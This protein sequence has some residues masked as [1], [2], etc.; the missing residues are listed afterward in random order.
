MLKR[1]FLIFFFAFTAFAASA[2]GFRDAAQ[3]STA[4]SLYK[5]ILLIPYNPIMHL[6]DADQDISEYSQKNVDIVRG[7]FRNGLLANLSAALNYRC[8][9]RAMGT[10]TS[11]ESQKELDMIYGSLNYQM[12][13]VFPVSHPAADTSKSSSAG[14]VV[15]SI[16][17]KNKVPNVKEIHDLKY[18]N[19]KLT[20]PELLAKLSEK[21]GADLLSFLNQFEIKTQ[22]D[23]CLD[24]ALKIYRRELKVHYSIFDV[25]GKQL[26]GDVVVV[27]FPSNTNDITEIME[28]NFPKI[29]DYIVKTVPRRKQ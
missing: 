28:R 17:A 10:S 25:S 22:Y 4:D 3:D 27:N 14:K 21:Y 11:K 18:M 24:L 6:S 15:K 20:H 19:I 9:T 16:F 5:K 26:Y 29:S 1:F 2:T 7:V 12:D 23:D 8:E 13:T